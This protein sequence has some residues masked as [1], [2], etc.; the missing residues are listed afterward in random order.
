[1]GRELSERPNGDWWVI[2][3]TSN[4]FMRVSSVFDSKEAVIGALK[5]GGL[6]PDALEQLHKNSCIYMLS[7]C[8]P[9]PSACASTRA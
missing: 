6:L 8:R 2:E 3:T 9:T 4:A 1:M 5:Q 7:P